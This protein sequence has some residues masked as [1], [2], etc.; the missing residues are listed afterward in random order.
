MDLGAWTLMGIVLLC[1][2]TASVLLHPLRAN[3]GVRLYEAVTLTI[4][5]VAVI[6]TAGAR[7]MA[8]AIYH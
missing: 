2:M 1:A 4:A 5:A 7:I 8:W 3:K 6:M